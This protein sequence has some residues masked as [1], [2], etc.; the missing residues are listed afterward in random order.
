MFLLNW[1]KEFIEI[2]A[3][4]DAKKRELNFCEACET[5]KL[6]LALANEERKFLIQKLTKEPEVIEEK[7]IDTSNL[8][9]LMPS[10]MNWNTRRQQLESEDRAAAKIINEKNKELKA[11]SGKT[12]SVHEIEKEL[13]VQE[14]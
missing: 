7:Q 8:R 14:G 9:P 11:N 2:K 13:G 12:L 5:L 6:Q 4:R 3:E 1:Y 10:R